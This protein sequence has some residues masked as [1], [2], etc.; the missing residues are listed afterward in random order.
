MENYE[1]KDGDIDAIHNAAT[2]LML[3]LGEPEESLYDIDE[4]AAKV[5]RSEIVGSA[6]NMRLVQVDDKPELLRVHVM[7]LCIATIGNCGIVQVGP[8][9]SP[10][11]VAAKIEQTE[12]TVTL[13]DRT[14]YGITGMQVMAEAPEAKHIGYSDDDRPEVRQEFLDAGA[15][16][17]I[18]KKKTLADVRAML[19]EIQRRIGPMLG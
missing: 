10:V 13:M 6:V 9:D 1:L 3:S 18:P 7:E 14:M 4:I 12:T 5:R 15:V 11:D 17:V 2:R 19:K 8:D 16:E